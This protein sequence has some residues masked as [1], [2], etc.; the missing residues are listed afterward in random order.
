MCVRVC[1]KMATTTTP[2]GFPIRLFMAQFCGRCFCRAHKILTSDTWQSH[3][4]MPL[5]FGAVNGGKV[6][7]DQ[8]VSYFVY[9]RM[10]QSEKVIQIGPDACVYVCF[11]CCVRSHHCLQNCENDIFHGYSDFRK[12][13]RFSKGI[14]L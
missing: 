5:Y 14:L 4:A 13:R 8:F 6:S 12:V 3:F 9:V 1:R 7:L 11:E 10:H 2:N